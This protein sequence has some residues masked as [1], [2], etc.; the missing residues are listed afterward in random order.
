MNKQKNI[1]ST[2]SIIMIAAGIYGAIAFFAIYGFKIVNP[3][4]D[5]WLYEGGDLTQHY[6]GWLFYRR[7]DWHFPIGLVDGVLS[8]VKY[9]VMYTDSIPIFAVFFKILSPI[10]P[11]TFQYFGLWGLLCFILSGVFSSLLIYKFN[12]NPIFC[13][14]GSLIYIL[15]PAVLHR[16][17][18]HETLAAHFIIILAL[19]LWAY[20]NHQWKKKWMQKLMPAILWGILGIITVN[21]HIY[22]LPMVY[23]I[24]LAAVIVD[25]G[26]NKKVFR[27]VSCFVSITV[28]SLLALALIGAFYGEGSQ[29]AV[30]LG[31]CSANLNTFWNGFEVGAGGI[32]AGESGVASVYLKESPLYLG[33]QFE[34]FAYL[35]LG[36]LIA[37]LLSFIICL[38]RFEKHDGKIVSGIKAEFI[39]YK[40]YIIAFFAAFIVALFFAV[41]PTCTLN[42]KVIYTINYPQKIQEIFAI[43]RA[44]GRFAWVC[45][46]LI[47]TGV[48]FILSKINSKKIMVTVLVLCVGI[49]IADLSKLIESKKYFKETKSY[50]SPLQD[51]HW[52]EFAASAEHL[53]I[54]PYDIP[55]Q[56]SYALG[57]YALENGLTMNHFQ[58]ARPPIDQIIQH[59]FD[60][61]N[62]ITEG[63]GNPDSIYVF[64]D[65]QYIPEA[66]DLEITE[67][68][69]YFVVR[70]NQT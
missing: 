35:G 10:L 61:I 1:L 69:G 8:D 25:F 70:C 19:V 60:T 64:L 16:M 57:K 52:N 50:V 41:S 59:Y 37:L 6:M 67:M 21:I 56:I 14:F 34:G 9:S 20:Q 32:F 15:C 44:S 3:M 49:Q 45:D 63:N 29:A 2:R 42:D 22:L 24:L 13:L 38:V 4:Y 7:S 18:G 11:D 26:K 68:D 33:W 46:Y 12:K 40:W 39:K 28:F 30:G 53:E 65:A 48:L 51:P 62:L 31:M 36:V 17:Y 54:L 55:S 5:D 27:P 58:V 47:F 66:D 43:F 23:C